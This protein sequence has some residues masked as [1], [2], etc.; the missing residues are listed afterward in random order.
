LGARRAH[1]RRRRGLLRVRRRVDRRGAAPLT[2][3]AALAYAGVLNSLGLRNDA[4]FA[5][6]SL[7]AVSVRAYLEIAI[8]PLWLYLRRTRSEFNGEEAA[9]SGNGGEP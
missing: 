5:G 7:V 3:V 9:D 2:L 1:P 6:P 4:G 8:V